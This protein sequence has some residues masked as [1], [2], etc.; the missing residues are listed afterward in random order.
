VVEHRVVRI[1]DRPEQ[2]GLV[3]VRCRHAGIAQRD[4]GSPVG[5]AT[6]GAGEVILQVRLVGDEPAQQGVPDG[7]SGSQPVSSGRGS[8]VITSSFSDRCGYPEGVRSALTLWG[9]GQSSGVP[10]W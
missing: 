1:T 4:A 9:P 3:Q 6:G 8:S 5:P 10:R 7:V 2:H